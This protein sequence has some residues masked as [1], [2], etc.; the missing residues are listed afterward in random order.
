M[1]HPNTQKIFQQALKSHQVGQLQA[2]EK[3]YLQVLEIDPA[4]AD[5]L[6]FLGVL[7]TQAGLHESAIQLIQQALALQ[8]A[9]A[10]M[11]LHLG[12]A[13]MA[14]KHCEDAQYAYEKACELEPAYPD[15]HCNLA[16]AL[17]WQ[18]KFDE[19][20]PVVDRAIKLNPKMTEALLT[21]GNCM[22][23][24]GQYAA[25]AEAFQM[26]L[27]TSPKHKEAL[28]GLGLSYGGLSNVDRA[29]EVFS[30]VVGLYPDEFDAHRNL[31]PMYQIKGQARLALKS[32]LKALSI[33]ESDATTHHN[34]GV[35][36]L[37]LGDV[38]NARASLDRAIEIDPDSFSSIGI[39]LYMACLHKSHSDVPYIEVAKRYGAI[40]AK[41][42]TPYQHWP[43]ADA[44]AQKH[45]QRLRI[46]IVSGD[47]KH[48][49]VGF[50]VEGF[51][52]AVDPAKVQLVAYF[53]HALEDEVS[54]L[55][56]PFFSE[57]HSVH[58]LSDTD[59]AQ[60]IHESGIQ[61]LIDLAGHTANN[62]LPLFAYKPAPIQVSWL[63]YLA[64]SGVAAMDY[65]LCDPVSAPEALQPDFTEQ[66]WRLPHT[67]N[68]LA[69][70]KTSTPV[71]VSPLPA[72][73]NGYVTFGCFQNRTKIN[74][75]VQQTWRQ[76]LEV[77]PNSRLYLICRNIG[78]EEDKQTFLQQLEL[79]GLP[80]NRVTLSSALTHRDD[81]LRSYQLIDISL[82][83]FPYP[84]VTTTCEALWMGVPVLT[85]AGDTML[86]RQGAALMTAVGLPDWVANSKEA[87]V[88][89]AIRKTQQLDKLA[90]LRSGLRA[91]AKA[92]PVF[93]TALFA[94][95]WTEAMQQMW[96]KYTEQLHQTI[97]AA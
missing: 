50:F 65:F 37:Q 66:L 91:Q 49:S 93:D 32:C 10:Q 48:H 69:E 94:R 33:H 88:D 40:V 55:L 47:L 24:T 85:L 34:K 6:H 21:K 51:V 68:C 36:E 89:I 53:N 25:A 17:L 64:S 3:G 59:L 74:D 30:R 72:Q 1:S 95:H 82:D 22:Y 84:G 14:L 35:A 19:C 60:K 76:I 79:N 4:H 46:G 96:A 16:Q 81:L 77:I 70:P 41:R 29:I 8:P 42:A 54:A 11:H 87:Y 71:Y 62:R 28:M 56:K 38:N 23:L 26:T 61:I 39:K 13:F 80:M 9:N 7:H 73:V 20:L 43:E 67:I 57:W 86:G 78:G 63:G 27:S 45:P 15:A 83:P 18:R 97:D 92:S 12:N 75:E 90:Q 5:A 31:G 44:W 58:N 52:K 2:A